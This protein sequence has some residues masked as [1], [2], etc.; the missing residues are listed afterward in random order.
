MREFNHW[1]QQQKQIKIKDAQ[2]K[3]IFWLLIIGVGVVT[4]II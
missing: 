3:L 2:D 1:S 4:W